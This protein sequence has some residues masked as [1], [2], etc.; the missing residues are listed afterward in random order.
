M[1]P[2]YPKS[3]DTA[4][5]AFITREGR[6]VNIGHTLSGDPVRVYLGAPDAGRYADEEIVV[7]FEAAQAREVAGHLL[8]VADMIESGAATAFDWNNPDGSRDS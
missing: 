6:T 5:R 2:K 7:W 3:P 1:D 4:N 8:E